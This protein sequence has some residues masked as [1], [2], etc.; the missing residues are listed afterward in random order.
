LRTATTYKV[1]VESAQQG[2]IRPT[3]CAYPCEQTKETMMSV[4][5]P[6]QIVQAAYAA[7]G[8]GDIPA[9]LDQLHSD[10]SWK[11]IGDV[12]APYARQVIGHEGVTSWFGDVSKADQIQAFEPREFLAG[13]D[14]VTVIGWERTVA[15]PGGG[16][17][18]SE[19]VHVWKLRGNKVANFLGILDSEAS[20]R[21]RAR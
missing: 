4:S 12:A 10:V 14:H 8:R 17:F 1:A 16:T 20:G 2:E 11:F 7:F 15:L 19:W 3:I 18:E 9:L 13:P 5:T 21:A 6:L